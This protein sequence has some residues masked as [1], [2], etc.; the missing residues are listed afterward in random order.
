MSTHCGKGTDTHA[1][2]GTHHPKKEQ[3]IIGGAGGGFKAHGTEAEIMKLEYKQSY[4]AIE[5]SL[6]YS[7]RMFN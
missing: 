3:I 4:L 7:F 2:E 1:R 6:F 5:H